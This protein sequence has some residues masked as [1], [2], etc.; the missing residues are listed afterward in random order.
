MEQWT[1]RLLWHLIL[2]PKKKYGRFTTIFRY[3]ALFKV[4]MEL[5]FQ[6]GPAMIDELK[7][8]GH[9]IF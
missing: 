1:N 8:K 5:Y 4:G 2:H 9:H 3:V 6:E 7:Q